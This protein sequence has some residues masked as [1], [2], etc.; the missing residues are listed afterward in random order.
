MRRRPRERKPPILLVWLVIGS[1][2]YLFTHVDQVPAFENAQTT[3]DRPLLEAYADMSADVYDLDARLLRR[4]IEAESN[5]NPEAVSPA[6]ARG[7]AQIMPNTAKGWGVNPD[8]PLESIQAMARY[9]SSRVKHW[10]KKGLNRREAYRK[11]L[12][13]Y[14]CGPHCENP[15][16]RETTGYIA[17]IDP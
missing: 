5:W 14:N 6:G 12:T 17:R 3:P 2:A 8:E 4:Q 1:M 16:N 11:A 13:D 9:M 15:H 7:I 10:R